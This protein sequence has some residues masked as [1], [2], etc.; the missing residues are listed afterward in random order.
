MA[1]NAGIPAGH[2]FRAQGR[3]RAGAHVGDGGRVENGL[4]HPG[5][6]IEQVHHRHFR[7]Q[8]VLVVIHIVADNLDARH[9]Q[10]LDIAAQHVEMTLGGVFGHQV[11]AGFDTGLA[12]ALRPQA[13]FHGGEDFRI[14]HVQSGDVGAIEIGEIAFLHDG[15]RMFRLQRQISGGAGIPEAQCF[16]FLN[17]QCGVVGGRGKG[18]AA[19]A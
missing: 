11:N 1:E 16:G 8:A 2:V 9:M 14:A 6:R 13:L 4:H 18:E 19:Q 17:R 7:G 5:L 3:D 12:E 10:G 15:L